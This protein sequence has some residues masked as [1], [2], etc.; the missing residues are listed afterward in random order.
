MAY[1]P[2]SEN[3]IVLKIFGCL[4]AKGSSVAH[5]PYHISYIVW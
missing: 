2:L 4:T 5:S 3:G 1:Q